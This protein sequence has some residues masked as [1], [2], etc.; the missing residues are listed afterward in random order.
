MITML[1][2]GC[3][4]RRNQKLREQL[5]ITYGIRASQ[6]WRLDRGLFTSSS[7]RVT[8]ET[9][10]GL[11]ETS[12]SVDE[13]ATADVPDAELDKSKQNLIRALPAQFETNAATAE[14]FAE[15]ALHGLPDSWYAHYSDQ[16][17]KE[18]AKDVRTVA[19]TALPAKQMVF[20]VV[21]AMA[22]VRADL[23][24]LYLGDA[25]AR[26]LYGMPIAKL[27]PLR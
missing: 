21:G 17:R 26:D 25:E 20:A 6:D 14:A 4:S 24:M 12:K 27:Q 2:G 13:L 10:H 15:L 8:A 5:G 19:K 1:G 11:A 22:K 3:T 23:D 9:A 7:A 18:T 16:I